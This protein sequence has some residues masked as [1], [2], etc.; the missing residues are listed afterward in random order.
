MTLARERHRE[1]PALRHPPRHCAWH[2]LWHVRPARADRRPDPRARRPPRARVRVLEP[3][4][5]AA[6]AHDWS[7]VDA[8]LAQ[9]TGEEEVW[10]TVCCQFAVGDTH[11]DRLPAALAAIDAAAYHRSCA[12]WWRAV[13]AACTIGSATTSRA[14]SAA[15]GGHGG[16]VRHPAGRVS[17]CRDGGGSERRGGAGRLRIRRPLQPPD[18]PP[19]AFFDEVLTAAGGCFDLFD[20]HLYDGPALIPRPPRHACGR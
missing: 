17:P 14:T 8:L 18:G 13:A 3:G 6:R 9:L 5:A 16:R 15:V 7:I 20:V 1:T 2:Q 19:R 11:R 4:R 12:S 10:V